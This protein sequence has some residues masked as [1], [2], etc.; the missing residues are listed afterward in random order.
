MGGKASAP[1]SPDYARLIPLQER[2]NINQFNTM[3]GAS[4][5]N[6]QTPWGTQRWIRPDTSQGQAPSQGQPPPPAPPQYIQGQIPMGDSGPMSGQVTNPEW[7]KWN[8][9]YGGGGGDGF[10]GVDNVYGGQSQD[11]WTMVQELSPEQQKLFEQDLRIRQGQGDISEGMLGNVADVYKNP[12]NFASLLPGYNQNT[13]DAA[14][15]AIYNRQM[16]YARPEMEEAER[17]QRERLTAMG[18]NVNDPGAVKAMDQLSRAQERQRADIRD[19]AILGGS[20]EASAELARGLQHAL[21]NIG[22]QSQD[23]ARYLNE[24]N[25]FRTGQQVQAPGLP[26][27]TS[28]PGLQGFDQL[29]LAGQDYQNRLGA[30]NAQNAAGG[31][32][33]SGLFGLGSAALMGPLFRG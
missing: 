31:N 9:Q 8:Q 27:Q 12:A 2:S 20:Q 17:S 28:V 16:R 32:F 5:V 26:G 18:F 15:R 4:R 1:A 11:P 19:Q 22:A 3:L 23:R 10:Q 21:A 13:R 6:S 25:A 24:L 29:G 14:E 7:E 30:V 33:M